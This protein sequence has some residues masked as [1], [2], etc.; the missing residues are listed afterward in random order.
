MKALLLAVAAVLSP[1]AS[2]PVKHMGLQL[3]SLR[4]DL[5]ADVAKGLDEVKAFGITYVEPHSTYGLTPAEF[6]HRLDERGLKAPSAHFPYERLDKDL[7]GVIEE[8]KLLG[9]RYV[10]LPW[11][12]D[13]TFN[14]TTARELAAHLNT[15]GATLRKAGLKLGYHPHGVEFVPVEGGGTAFDLLVRSTNAA[16]VCFELDVFW[17]AHAGAD[18]VALL[19][20]YPDRWKLLH[21]KDMSK[22][23][24][25]TPGKRSAPQADNV[26]MGLGQIDWPSLLRAAGKIGIEYYF[27][28]DE[29]ATPQQN[30]P[31]SMAYLKAF[32][33]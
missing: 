18:P 9:A 4:Q 5:G 24:V 2:A 12:P 10:I 14:A 16:D 1:H 19:T 27:L 11:L 6:R 3:W 33:P 15:W 17:A 29:T 21:L 28:E 32:K 25:I 13:E 8:A 31:I 23:A 30:I 22:D 7:P 20:R 26:A